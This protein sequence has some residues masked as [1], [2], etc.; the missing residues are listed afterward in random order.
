M[1]RIFVLKNPTD[2]GSVPPENDPANWR[3][4]AQGNTSY[5]PSFTSDAGTNPGEVIEF[6]LNP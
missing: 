4:L 5:G 2:T 6:F 3:E 1:P